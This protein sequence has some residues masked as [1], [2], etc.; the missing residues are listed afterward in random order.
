MS[1]QISTLSDEK[2]LLAKSNEENF[3]MCQE[4]RLNMHNEV[5]AVRKERDQLYSKIQ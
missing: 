1:V 3:R 2:L 4:L 5:Q